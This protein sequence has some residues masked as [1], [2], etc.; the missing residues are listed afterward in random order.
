MP[1]YLLICVLVC[2][3]VEGKHLLGKDYLGLVWM[4]EKMLWKSW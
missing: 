3:K 4:L 1:I 2:G